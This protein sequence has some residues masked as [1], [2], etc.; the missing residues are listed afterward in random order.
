MKIAIG[1]ILVELFGLAWGT[2][3]L[4]NPAVGGDIQLLAWLISLVSTFGLL[5]TSFRFA[6]RPGSLTLRA[7][8]AFVLVMILVFVCA[9]AT[10][11]L[12]LW[13]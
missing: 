13:V 10:A 8:L 4:C 3:L 9:I 2:V 6:R 11:E 1:A 5:A 12:A 7:V